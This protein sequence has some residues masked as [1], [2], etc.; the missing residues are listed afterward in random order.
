VNNPSNN[1]IA[2]DN[3]NTPIPITGAEEAYKPIIEPLGATD[4]GLVTNIQSNAEF[5]AYIIL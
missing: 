1:D 4:P 5:T 2:A 3:R